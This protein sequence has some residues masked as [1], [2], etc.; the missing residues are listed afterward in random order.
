MK[1]MN[2]IKNTKWIFI[3]MCIMFII[4]ILVLVVNK[5]EAFTSIKIDDYVLNIHILRDYILP[6][7]I[8]P[9]IVLI[10]LAY[11][12]TIFPAIIV[13]CYVLYAII[14]GGL[15]FN[16]STI[17]GKFIPLIVSSIYLYS[18]FQS[19]KIKTKKRKTA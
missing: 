13:I 3:G 4:L 8:L 17:I 5:G 18:Y 7:I 15:R 6:F 16:S 10:I 2:K 14:T 11:F 19:K 1:M 12:E 9:I